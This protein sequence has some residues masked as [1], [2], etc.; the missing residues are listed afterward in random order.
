MTFATN[1]AHVIAVD[2]PTAAGKTT[3]SRLLANVLR[4]NYLE[5][6]RAYRLVAY[7]ALQY[8]SE[9]DDELQLEG[10]CDEIISKSGVT[11]LLSSDG[12]A[13]PLRSPE[14]DRAITRVAGVPGLREKITQ[15]TRAWAN[16]S[17]PCVIEGRDIGTVVFP[18]SQVKF[19]LTASPEVRAYRRHA[20]ESGRSYEAVLEDLLRRDKVDS[21]R[22]ASPLMPATDANI[23]DTTDMSVPEVVDAMLGRCRVHG[24]SVTVSLARQHVRQDD[25]T[26]DE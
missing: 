12:S 24:F 11:A 17:A 7:T 13:Y 3:T 16:E 4:L 22:A 15:L 6:G 10:L 19:F 23:I 14:V 26:T 18:T 1:P 5:S 21:S 20:Q 9:L 25:C 8:G 2:G